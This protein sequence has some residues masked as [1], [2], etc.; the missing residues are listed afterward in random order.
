MNETIIQKRYHNFP[1]LPNSERLSYHF[2]TVENSSILVD[3]FQNDDN[4]FVD[5]RFQDAAKAKEYA[6]ESAIS[7]A[8]AKHGGCDFFIC[9]KDTE[10]YIGVLH[11]YELSLEQFNDNH[12]RATIGFGI[13]APFRR[14]YYAME[15][16][17]HLIDYVQNTLKKPNILAYTNPENI[18]A[19]DFLLSL[20]LVLSDE[21][22]IYEYNYYELKS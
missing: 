13:A 9:L 8:S 10:T 2:L 19:N 21:D 15:A 22:Y 3:L 5:N 1:N 16:V 6:Y 7:R 12:L 20:G 4:P 14:Q 17:K 18:A 11:L